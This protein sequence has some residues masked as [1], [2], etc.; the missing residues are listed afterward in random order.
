M[1]RRVGRI[2]VRLLWPVKGTEFV[3]IRV[4]HVSEMHGAKFALTQAR[5][6]FDRGASMCD[7]NVMKLLHLRRR[8]ALEPNGSAIGESC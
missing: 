3:A 8:V 5:R 2:A 4:T 1:A 6:S 7:G